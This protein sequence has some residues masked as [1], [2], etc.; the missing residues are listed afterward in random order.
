MRLLFLLFALFIFLVCVPLAVGGSVTVALKV[1]VGALADIFCIPRV[2]AQAL[3]GWGAPRLPPAPPGRARQAATAAFFAFAPAGSVQRTYA[4]LFVPAAVVLLISVASG[5][6]QL[7]GMSSRVE[8]VWREGLFLKPL[9]FVSSL[10]MFEDALARARWGASGQFTLTHVLYAEVASFIMATSVQ[11]VP[12]KMAQRLFHGVSAYLAAAACALVMSPRA[13]A[14]ATCSWVLFGA[15]CIIAVVTTDGLFKLAYDLAGLKLLTPLGAVDLFARKLIQLKILKFLFDKCLEL[16]ERAFKA[17]FEVF[18]LVLDGIRYPLWLLTDSFMRYVYYPFDLFVLWPLGKVLCRFLDDV[19]PAIARAMSRALATTFRFLRDTLVDKILVPG[20]KTLFPFAEP[21]LATVAAW[22]F[23]SA[24]TNE[25]T[26]YRAAP[27]AAASVAAASVALIV[28][29]RKTPAPLRPVGASLAAVGLAAFLHLDASLLPVLR[30]AVIWTYRAIAFVLDHLYTF[31]AAIAAKLSAAFAAF[32]DRYVRPVFER[33]GRRVLV[34]FSRAIENI[35]ASPA[36]AALASA[37]VLYALVEAHRA[38]LGERLARAAASALSVPAELVARRC[39]RPL[40]RAGDAL[41]AALLPSL[42]RAEEARAFL[43]AAALRVDAV[44]ATGSP[45]AMFRDEGFAWLVYGAVTLAGAL[46]DVSDVVARVGRS[47]RAGTRRANAARRE[48]LAARAEIGA[49][50]ALKASLVPTL[51]G[52]FFSLVLSPIFGP[53][54]VGSDRLFSLFL[55]ASLRVYVGVVVLV[56][57]AT[58]WRARRDIADLAGGGGGGA[59]AGNEMVANEI[60]H[61]AIA[62]PPA[63]CFEGDACVV[64]VEALADASATDVDEAKKEELAAVWLPCGHG[65][66]KACITEWLKRRTLCPTCRQDPRASSF[67]RIAI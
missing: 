51:F 52:A 25:P 9:L 62:R 20:A 48:A 40:A 50:V 49:R 32:M 66:H 60:V 33:I 63:R 27:F 28:V 44:V 19:L 58:Q 41:A 12:A 57:W 21:V 8:R 15:G 37:S 22:E 53:V 10:G 16:L 56:V 65:F 31:F 42:D 17:A 18:A 7:L 26:A 23:A 35:W 5:L 43:A 61:D 29:G 34:A 1:V 39:A 46:T 3:F 38:N 59:R 24:A 45:R 11:V 47:G 64:C 55:A 4:F 54:G 67:E 6:L 30:R 36:L 13:T 14:S 2:L